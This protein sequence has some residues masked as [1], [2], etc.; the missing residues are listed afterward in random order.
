[1][2]RKSE[3]NSPVEKIQKDQ[4]SQHVRSISRNSPGLHAAGE[5]NGI[6]VPC[7]KYDDEE[8]GPVFC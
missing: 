2:P 7:A 3:V 1:M 4:E 8:K 6:S 5:V